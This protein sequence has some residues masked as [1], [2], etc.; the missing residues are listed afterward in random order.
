[1]MFQGKVLAS[2]KFLDCFAGPRVVLGNSR[3]PQGFHGGFRDVS[4]RFNS[5]Q[6]DSGMF[7]CMINVL[8]KILRKECSVEFQ[9]ISD[10]F[11]RWDMW[12]FGRRRNDFKKVPRKF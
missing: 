1:M 6:S 5:T 10:K 12:C 4:G 9:L 3:E 7:I 2:V 8:G 11:K